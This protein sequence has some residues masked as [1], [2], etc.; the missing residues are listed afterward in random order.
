MAASRPV[1]GRSEV[2]GLEADGASPPEAAAIRSPGMERRL[3]A[4]V[5]NVSDIVTV[6][7]AD[8]AIRYLTPAAGRMLGRPPGTASGLMVAELVHAD[9]RDAFARQFREW[10][11]AP[12]LGASI[13]YRMRHAQGGWRTLE[14]V[15]ENLLDDPEVAGV[16]VT[17]HDVTEERR[18]EGD[19]RASEER[20][21]LLVE[22]SPET[23]AVHVDGRLVYINPAGVRLLGADTVDEVIGRDVLALVHP[24]DRELAEQ[25]V[26]MAM[27]GE[28]SPLEEMRLVRDDGKV[29]DVEVIG[30]PVSFHGELANQILVRDV[31]ERHQ[32]EA[33]LAHRALH[34][35][36]TGLPN[37]SLLLD[38]LDQALARLR[39]HREERSP[40]APPRHVA[41]LFCDLDGFKAV[42]DSRGHAAG[43]AL[44]IAVAHRLRGALRP[45][46]TVARLGGDE[47]VIL[48]QDLAGTEE[49]VAIAERMRE[50]LRE[51]ITVERS[52]IRVTLSTGVVVADGSRCPDDLLR[53]ADIAMYRA[54]ERGRDCCEL[55]G[56]QRAEPA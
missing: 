4:L 14:S 8:G 16:V 26:R 40:A 55:A 49:A 29:I 7:D 34:D 38:R 39:R 54:K 46:D 37:R 33:E 15:A 17:S 11:A 18:R 20:Y 13:E 48:G 21:R 25:R 56:A 24:D 42:N 1:H 12:G 52:P 2:L 50:A 53:D 43:D 51:P 31:T 36:L 9:H 47:F 22:R 3:E 10:C 19:L 45:G 23:V 28:P 27:A 6:H 35:P 41:V 44:L 30:N 32:A 5:A